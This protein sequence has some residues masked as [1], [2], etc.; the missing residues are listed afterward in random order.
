[1]TQYQR[2]TNTSAIDWS[3]IPT[4]DNAIAKKLIIGGILVG[5]IISILK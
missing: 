2:N 3:T 1:M 5:V 4:D